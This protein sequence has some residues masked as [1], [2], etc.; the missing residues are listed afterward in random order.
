MGIPVSLEEVIT[1]RHAPDKK[2]WETVGTPKLYV[3]EHYRMGFELTAKG[4]S[5]QVRIFIDYRL[6]ATGPC[7][8][9][10]RMLGSV[11][12]HWCTKRMAEDVAKHFNPI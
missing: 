9:L 11:Y 4:D 6:P 2:V 10:G 1:E 7:F 12:A 8:W 3:M 5:S